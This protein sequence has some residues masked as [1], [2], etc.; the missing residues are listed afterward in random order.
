MGNTDICLNL[1][2]PEER[3]Q[4]DFMWN[5]IPEQDRQGM[6]KEDLLFVL[7][8]VDDFLEEA[9]LLEVNSET[10]EMTYLDGDVDENAELEYVQA[11][12]RKVSSGK[13][14][15]CSALTSSQIQLI[16]DAELQYGIEKGY[17]EE[18]D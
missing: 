4:L 18:E 10:G 6:Q 9:G 7:D 8:A 5:L 15:Q 2:E 16:L 1:L 14:P 13:H 17:Y 11:V 3:E 12:V